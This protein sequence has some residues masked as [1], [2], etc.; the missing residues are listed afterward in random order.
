[1]KHLTTAAI[2]GCM[3]L[4]A[5][6]GGESSLPVGAET[7]AAA[8][9]TS[10]Q[11][12]AAA[13][14]IVIPKKSAGAVLKPRYV[15]S[16]TQSLIGTLTSV[17]GTA[18]PS[19]TSYAINV[20]NA[21]CST[22]GGGS[23][24][25]T[26]V[27]PAT[28]GSDTFTISTYDAQQSAPT[29]AT[30]TGNLLS[31]Q[32]TTVTIVANSANPVTVPVALDGI[33]ATLTLTL[34]SLGYNWYGTQHIPLSFAPKD[35]DGNLIVGPGGLR[36]PSGN[37][38]T[39]TV[40]NSDTSGVTTLSGATFTATT[41]ARA[42]LNYTGGPFSGT[43]TISASAP[44]I[45]TTTAS[46]SSSLKSGTIFV[47][48][49]SGTM[50]YDASTTPA[51]F[52]YSIGSASGAAYG[53]AIDANSTIYQSNFSAGK[54]FE[55]TLGALT[56]TTTLT[57]LADPITI[58]R[59][60]TG[61]IY[62]SEEFTLPKYFDLGATTPTGTAAAPS[63]TTAYATNYG[64]AVDPST[65]KLVTTDYSREKVYAYLSGPLTTPT[66]ILTATTPI[67]MSA[68]RADGS[69]LVT[70]VPSTGA[71]TTQLITTP[72]ATPGAATLFAN[73][74]GTTN[75]GVA[76]DA[77][78]NVYQSTFSGT[79]SKVPAGSALGVTGTPII[80]GASGAFQMAFAP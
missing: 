77:A 66:T 18:V 45:T 3:L 38:L 19:P 70:Y 35:S 15:S 34:G 28:A 58:A 46:F 2:A 61:R 31:T 43:S 55:Y 57:G 24:T 41:L 8:A 22:P 27:V 47:G 26:L 29:V 5:C 13:F 52:K 36:D 50:V 54:I 79:I 76:V 9:P 32:T 49:G 73:A 75:Y 7:G 30:P 51:V 10:T 62:A 39:V 72:L 74:V 21:S 11:R 63:A 6:S 80:T 64:V 12:G 48:S 78:G 16:S 59:D 25:C 17:G 56:P 44:G 20:G 60:S 67:G 71:G 53:V 14:T 4:A 65:N 1:M 33:A 23:A 40:T 37:P 69:L 68:F 42:T